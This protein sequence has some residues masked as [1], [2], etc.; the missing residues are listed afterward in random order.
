MLLHHPPGGVGA[1]LAARAAT[2]APDIDPVV[3]RRML[4][5]HGYEEEAEA[6]AET[7]A[8]RLVARL[9]ERADQTHMSKDTISSRLR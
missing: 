1:Q 7:L 3:A 9:V 6:D 8:T 4:A 5:R 2:A